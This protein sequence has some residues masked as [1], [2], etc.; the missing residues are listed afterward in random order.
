[1]FD[2]K[3]VAM[4]STRRRFIRRM[5]LGAGASLLAPLANRW[6]A[7]A[8]G[9]ELSRKKVVFFLFSNGFS[10]QGTFTPAGI[11]PGGNDERDQWSR[12]ETK[13]FVLPA[14]AKPVAHLRNQ[15]LL[16]DGLQNR[17]GG[18]HS[19]Y[20]GSLSGHKP[21]ELNEKGSVAP[22]I[23]ID[24]HI[25]KVLGQATPKAAVRFGVNRYAE[26]SI[27]SIFAAGPN[28]P[29]PQI[30]N[31]GVLYEDL[32]GGETLGQDRSQQ[33]L[34]KFETAALLS[35]VN[36]D[37]KRLRAKLAGPE[38][39][40]LDQHLGALET[41]KARQDGVQIVDCAAPNV[42]PALKD[43]TA[44]AA[45]MED[46]LEA[47]MDMGTV[48]L[49]C[50]MTNVLGI[51][52]NTGNPHVF[53]SPMNRNGQVS[54]NGHSPLEEY[55]AGMQIYHHY[56]L[57]LLA[58]M[59]QQLSMVQDGDKTVWDN[60]VIVYLSCN[61]EAHHSR[62]HRWPTML[63][64]NAGG[65]LK[66]DGRFLRYARSERALVDLFSTIATGVGVPTNDFGKGGAEMVK[67]PLSEILKA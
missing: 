8:Q 67:G 11:D 17:C 45:Y 57:G 44:K 38:K 10:P 32:F 33:E 9:A 18:Q 36:H 14:F 25:A 52:A 47:M 51:A 30:T 6:I 12:V 55:V 48:A 15:L 19:G 49:A 5:G 35:S 61:G 29:I 65:G 46:R 54:Y 28:Q 1:M 16:V 20:F 24:Q 27:S 62:K 4:L 13:D 43:P 21:S 58:K 42:N 53:W 26:R 41:F 23:T 66:V 50:G 31:P 59:I 64:G 60:T 22:A 34:A 56:F 37:I 40:K 63:I 2:R 7:E 3:E 39:A